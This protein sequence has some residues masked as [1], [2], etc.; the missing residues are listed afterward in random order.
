M[1]HR[2]RVLFHRLMAESF[3][4]WSDASS[5]AIIMTLRKLS[6]PAPTSAPPLYGH[7]HPSRKRFPTSSNSRTAIP[8]PTLHQTLPLQI[9][10]HVSSSHSLMTFLTPNSHQ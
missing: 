7:L 4:H 8:R 6:V 3:Y 9:R 5:T 10:T 2:P 1:S